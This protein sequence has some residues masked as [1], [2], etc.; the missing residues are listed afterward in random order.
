MGNIDKAFRLLSNLD[1]DMTCMIKDCES[2]STELLKE[3][4]E[5]ISECLK[6]LSNTNQ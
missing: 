1:A 4:Q 5:K 6:L 3:Y 2:F